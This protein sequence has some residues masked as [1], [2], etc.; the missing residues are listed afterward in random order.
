MSICLL[1]FQFQFQSANCTLDCNWIAKWP[2]YWSF[3]SNRAPLRIALG[4]IGR[5]HKCDRGP[6]LHLCDRKCNRKCNPGGG[7]G[8]GARGTSGGA[9]GRD[10][11]PTR[12][13]KAPRPLP[14]RG[15]ADRGAG[16][17]L[18]RPP[19]NTASEL[20]FKLVLTQW[21][22]GNDQRESGDPPLSGSLGRAVAAA[23]AKEDIRR[24]QDPLWCA[25]GKVGAPQGARRQLTTRHWIEN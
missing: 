3:Q 7:N 11:P 8:G 12:S 16:P 4:A 24:A 17:R 13:H 25:P 14:G 2:V 21:L 20:I 9:R 23:A 1:V 5:S 10:F 22:R 15:G 19:K 6:L 18:P